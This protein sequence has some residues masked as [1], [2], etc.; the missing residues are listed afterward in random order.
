MKD[1]TGCRYGLLL[2]VEF[3]GRNA[4]STSALWK[5][6]CDCGNFKVADGAELRMGRVD[7]CGCLTPARRVSSQITH[8][9]SH[10]VGGKATKEWR[11]WFNLRQRCNN[12]NAMQYSNYGGRGIKVCE[13]WNDYNNFLK[14]MGRCPK[15]CS[16]IDRIDN[17][18]DY[19][20]SNCRWTSNKEQSIN[21]RSTKL[22]TVNGITLCC[23]DWAKLNNLAPT[24]IS[25]R[26]KRGWTLQSAVSIPA[27]LGNRHKNINREL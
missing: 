22:V 24:T 18:G 12:P 27:D 2:V 19:T 20:P 11:A 3:A 21:R 1:I 14:D 5:C 8:G 26:V 4:R 9:E 6:K 10:S 25:E 15:T 13:R 17:D 7:H 23:R 16:S